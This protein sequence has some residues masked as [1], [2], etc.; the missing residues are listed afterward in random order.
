M[1]WPK[2]VRTA[3]W[4]NGVLTLDREKQ[5]EIPEL[6]MERLVGDALVGFHVKGYPV[7]NELLAPLPGIKAWL[8]AAWT[9]ARS[10][11]LVFSFFDM[12]TLMDRNSNINGS[13]LSALQNCKLGFL[14]LTHIWLDDASLL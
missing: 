12:P 8:T 4:E 7:T 5:S 2:R 14:A 9:T 3:D 1:K 6:T 13:E 11:T 10:L